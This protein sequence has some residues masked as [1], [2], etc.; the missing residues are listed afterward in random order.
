MENP[1]N[2]TNLFFIFCLFY[3][4]FAFSQKCMD[5][6]RQK[7]W[8]RVNL[9]SYVMTRPNSQT[10]TTVLDEA[11]G[12][13]PRKFTIRYDVESSKQLKT[14]KLELEEE[15]IIKILKGKS[16][17]SDFFVH[18]HKDIEKINKMHRSISEKVRYREDK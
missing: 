9:P 18:R 13:I 16:T 8:V 12:I 6:L 5:E 1:E 17:P 15:E 7:T 3:L 2:L 10:D 4:F 11:K 14:V